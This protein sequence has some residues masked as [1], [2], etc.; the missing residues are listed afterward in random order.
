MIYLSHDDTNIS[1][2]GY[3]M[4][5]LSNK[6]YSIREQ[7]FFGYFVIGMIYLVAGICFCFKQSNLISWVYVIGLFFHI[8]VRFVNNKREIQ[9]D[10]ECSLQSKYKA[11]YM[12][13]KLGSLVLLGFLVYH[14]VMKGTYFNLTLNYSHIL[15]V[16][17]VLYIYYF[18]LFMYYDKM[19]D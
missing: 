17:G 16:L 3:C 6:L 1:H 13:F 9:E 11:G 18:M 19:G 15:I 10:D 7:E 14:L 4:K 5:K 12:I 2:G 8:V